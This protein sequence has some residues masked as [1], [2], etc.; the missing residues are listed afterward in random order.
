MMSVS[1]AR[2]RV[3][4]VLAVAKKNGVEDFVV[5]ARTDTLIWRGPI[6]DAIARGKTYLAAGAANVFV[7]GCSVRGGLT[8][9]EVVELTSAFEGKL[10]VA[11]KTAPG[12]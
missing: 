12:T 5:N 11:F 6:S 8:R 10:N 7:W 9:S 2:E 3:K 4:R 1:V